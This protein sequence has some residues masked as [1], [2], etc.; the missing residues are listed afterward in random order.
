MTLTYCEGIGAKYAGLTI[1]GTADLQGFAHTTISR[2]CRELLF[3]KKIFSKQQANA[4]LIQEV[5]GDLQE[6]FELIG[7]QQ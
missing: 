5:K 6:F 4:F 7:Q 1:S 3:K 2:V